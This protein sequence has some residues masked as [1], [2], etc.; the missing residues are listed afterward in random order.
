LSVVGG[1]TVRSISA[2][3]ISKARAISA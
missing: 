3:S 2:A 1:L